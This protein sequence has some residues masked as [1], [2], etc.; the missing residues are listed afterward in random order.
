MTTPL[1]QVRDLEV[2]LEGRHRR[3]PVDGV[4]FEVA[5]GSTVGLVGESG[6]G[7]SMTALAVMGLLPA[8]V[9]RVTGGE[10]R[11]DGVD[12]VSAD[13]ATLR[14][15]RGNRISMVF[16]EPMT[17]LN[18]VLSCG[19]QIAE[20]LRLHRGLDRAAAAE[21][22]VELL[23]QVRIPDPGSR[24]RQYPHQLSGGMRQR[25]MIAMAIACGPG[26]LIAD[27]PTTALDVTIQREILDLLESLQ[28]D[29]GMGVLHITHD[30][31]VIASTAE[32]V[33][34]MY[35]G[36]IVE[37]GPV[38]EVLRRPTHPYTLGLLACRPELGSRRGRLPVIGGQVP[39]LHQL[40]SGC[41]FHD[42]CPFVT[43]ACR[44]EDPAA[45]W[46]SA[47]HRVHCHHAE[48]VRREGR[49]PQHAG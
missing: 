10:V 35:A 18:P 6:C 31:G 9:A 26:L 46:P 38:E 19:E 49:W 25:V 22:T 29:L 20:V 8:R 12:L 7:K 33:M 13:D 2:S 1:L 42:R 14:S 43:D 45:T 39:E 5:A 24:A 34:V 3:V 16:Q 27:E 30:L 47:D 11:L 37:A 21:R 17:S 41:R 48:A 32:T 23:D 36:R 40:P 15:L 44:Q 28:K 4:S